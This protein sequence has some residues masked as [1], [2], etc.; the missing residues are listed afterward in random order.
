M[1]EIRQVLGVCPQK[2]A[3]AVAMLPEKEASS[4][5]ELRLRIGQY[6]TYLRNDREKRLHNVRIC[7]VDLQEVIERASGSSVYAVQD[8]LKSGFITIGGGH[9]IGLCGRGVYKDNALS[10]LRDISSSTLRPPSTSRPTSR[11]L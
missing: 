4:I 1:D 2:I 10:A 9:R 7:E 6:P 11:H 5:E 8:M 3:T